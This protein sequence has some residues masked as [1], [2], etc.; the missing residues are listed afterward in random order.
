MKTFFITTILI[1]SF[2]A[3]AQSAPAPVAD[4]ASAICSKKNQVEKDAKYYNPEVRKSHYEGTTNFSN[5]D[6]LSRGNLRKLYT[7]LG[8]RNPEFDWTPYI[9]VSCMDDCKNPEKYKV[10]VDKTTE[11]ARAC[12]SVS[13]VMS[14][15]GRDWD[16]NDQIQG[17]R[18]EKPSGKNA[19]QAQ[20]SFIKCESQ[21]LETLDYDACKKFQTQLELI[22]GI[23]QVSYGAQELVYKDKMMDASVK[24]STDENVATGALKASG[25]SL[26]MQQDM[27]QQRTAVDATKLAYL[28]SIYNDMPKSSDIAEKCNGISQQEALGLGG[29]IAPET[30]KQAIRPGQGGFAITMNQ[31]QLD[32]M[33]SKL[34]TIATSAG[35]NILLSSLL[36]KR[37]D[38][39]NKA[40]AK[41]DDFKPVDPFVTPESEAQTTF[42]KQ[43][44][45]LAQC[46]TGDLDRT[47]DTINDNIITFGEGGTG[48]SYGTNNAINP[49][50]TS[51]SGETST[52][53]ATVTPVGSVITAAAQDN[54][55]EAS[56]AATVKEAGVGGAAPGGGGGGASANGGGGGGAPAATA[57][58]GVAAAVQ[59]KTPKYEGGTG[60]IS[61]VGGFGINKAKGEGKGDDNPF[62]KLFGKDVKPSGVVNFREIASQKV[63]TKGDNLF[64]MISKRYS[65]V[66]ADKRLLEYELTK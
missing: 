43:N 59:G 18:S 38:D 39:V 25:E 9:E 33:K 22:E 28:Y 66:T 11:K 20:A 65:T 44:P 34:I 19:Q 62:G 21:G 51:T 17:T 42:C 12:E 32:A 26:K 16:D 36:G 50:T 40:I 56:K 3:M 47:F 52:N 7:R 55:I 8:T 30:C 35:S 61:V 57:A 60:S 14:Y 48:T 29:K 37:V 46:L 53:R 23:Q 64:D 24:H 2:K 6:T 58:G 4:Q 5:C 63:G 45:G 27:Y 54:S 41:I 1:F 31:A 10:C 15:Y 13:Y 49:G